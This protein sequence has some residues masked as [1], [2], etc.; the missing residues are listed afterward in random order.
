MKLRGP[1]LRLTISASSISGTTSRSTPRSCTAPTPPG[2]P[3]PPWCAVWKGTACPTTFTP[4]GSCRCLPMV[5][6][7]VDAAERIRDFLPQLDELAEEGMVV[8][9]EVEVIRYVGR[10]HEGNIS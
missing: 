7:I 4:R 3:A 1:A 8:V 6:T 5:I 9:D 2:W 10:E